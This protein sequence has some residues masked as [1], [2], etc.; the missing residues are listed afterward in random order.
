MNSPLFDVVEMTPIQPIGKTILQAFTGSGLVASLVANHVIDC[1]GLIE[2]GYISSSL[3]PSVGIVRDGIIQR[4]IRIYESDKYILVLSEVAIIEENLVEFIDYLF[5]WY[6]KIDPSSLIIIGALPTGRPNDATDL[7]YNIVASDDVTRE[8]L[9]EKGIWT[10]PQG[11]IYGSVA[12]SLMESKR[13]GIACFS[14]LSHCIA[15]I[16]DYLAAKKVSEL[17]NI[18]LDENMDLSKLNAN[19]LELK[20]HLINRSKQSKDDLEY[21]DY[22]QYDSYEYDES[23][24]D[25]EDDDLS[26]FI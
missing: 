24:D 20:D 13:S 14:I 17:L 8:F 18:V 16:P 12:L 25:D 4:P 21:D 19:A 23:I 9:S 15:T 6:S 3:I 1:L 7:R 5:D 10:L 26:A 11:A 22:N 2:K